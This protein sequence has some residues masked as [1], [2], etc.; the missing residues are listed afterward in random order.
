MSEINN[1]NIV[2]PEQVSEKGEEFY[3]NKLK[4]ILEPID[5]GKFVAIEIIS[6][7]YFIGNSILE[8][9]DAAKKKYPDRLFHTIKIGYQ[10]IFKMGGYVG[11]G[12][13]YNSI[14]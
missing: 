4:S 12:L 5:N 11:N 9:L 2:S 1:Q 13:S 10:G 14:L 6:G 3:K 7:D 8:A